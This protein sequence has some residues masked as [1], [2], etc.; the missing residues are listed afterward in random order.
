MSNVIQF[1]QSG[2]KMVLYT[3]THMYIGTIDN[4]EVMVDR[5]AIWLINAAILPIKSQVTPGEVLRLSSV[6]VMWDKVVAASP[7]PEFD[8]PI[9]P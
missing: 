8:P 7:Y 4:R 5:T 9:F 1:P 6:L 2:E 3:D